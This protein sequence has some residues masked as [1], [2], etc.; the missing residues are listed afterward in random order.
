MFEINELKNLTI[1]LQQG[2]WT[3]SAQESAVLLN[4]INKI[5][6]EI[7]RLETEAGT[8]G[9]KIDTEENK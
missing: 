3:I 7:K 2:K 9:E 6:E 1:L 5:N 8:P 4:L